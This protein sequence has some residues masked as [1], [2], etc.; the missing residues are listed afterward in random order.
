MLSYDELTSPERELWDA[1]P[2]GRRVDLRTGTPEEDRVADGGRWGPER[3]VRAAVIAAL[4]LGAN[5]GQPGAVA[6]LR[7]TGARISGRLDLAGAQIAHALWL[8]ACW[9][10]E[11]VNLLGAS[12]QTL[13]FTDSRIPGIEADSAR[14]EGNFSLRHAV[15]EGG[16]PTPFNRL[17]TALSLTDARVSGGLLL[18]G[19]E[20]IA[21]DGWALSAGGLAMEG[22]VFCRNGFVAYGEVR[23]MGAQ[24]PGTLVMQGAR[25][26][27]PGPRGVALTLDNAM[28][29]S[30]KFS[31]GF[32]ANGTVRLRGTQV[33]D[34]VTFDGAVLNGPPTDDGNAPALVAMHLQAVDLDLTLART[35]SGILDLRG[36]QVSYLHENDHSWPERVE[37]DG[38][39]YGSIKTADPN[40]ERHEAVGDRESVARRVA[41]IRSSPGYNPQPYEQLAAWYRKAGHDDDARR[42]LLAKQRH[43]R[44]A[45]SPAARAWG[46]LLDVTVGYGYRPWLAGVWL[47]A[48]T[49]MGTLSFRTDSPNP[50]KQGEGPPFQPLVYTLDLLIPIG[51]LGQRTSWYWPNDGLQW[52]AYLLI[53]FGWVLTTA[54]IAG[55]TRTLQKN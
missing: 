54:V 30:L 8:E 51:G 29:S 50:V 44:R 23:L 32:T 48:L 26:E 15:V 42:V 21:P 19:A 52:L 3:T 31:E 36:A 34:N 24:L 53:A 47:L 13:V 39:V 45:L 12:T 2:E 7:L 27:G 17:R 35:P 55:V 22:G 49:L 14:I 33:R 9:F 4:L 11:A 41:W 5:T 20:L 43:R 37:L 28:A 16:A 1:F 18:N 38:F 6:R 10:E 46:H 40:D 25:L